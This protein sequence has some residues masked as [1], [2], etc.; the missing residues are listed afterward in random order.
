M[1]TVKNSLTGIMRIVIERLLLP[2]TFPVMRFVKDQL[3]LHR[4]ANDAL[5]PLPSAALLIF[6]ARGC[7]HLARTYRRA[8][9]DY[10][11]RR[12]SRFVKR[13][14]GKE[15]RG[16]FSYD[17]L[18]DKDKAALY[19]Q[20]DGRIR[21]FIETFPDLLGYNNGDSFFDAGCGR[22]QNVKVLREL[23][24]NSPILAK[25][26]SAEVVSVIG[27]A[28]AS[29]LVTTGTVDLSDPVSLADLGDGAYDHVIISHVLSVVLGDGLDA[30]RTLRQRII[31]DLVRVARKSLLIIDSPAIVADR[32]GFEIEQMDRGWFAGSVRPYFAQADGRIITLQSGGSVGILY[33]PGNGR[34]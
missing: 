16:Y 4:L 21:G 29:P 26:I 23:F 24:P 1:S 11:L 15:G 17:G 31:T 28:A 3:F 25:D 9:D 30:T 5:P 14:Y 10:A 7:T 6:F 2:V 13:H 32:E 20:P 12:Y 27:L 18:S 8:F 19:G 34:T 22:G 33:Q